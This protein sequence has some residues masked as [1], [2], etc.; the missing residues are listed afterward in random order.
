MWKKARP[1]VLGIT[2][3]VVALQARLISAREHDTELRNYL[4]QGNLYLEQGKLDEALKAF[5]AA[6]FISGSMGDLD[7]EASALEGVSRIY[8]KQGR[9]EEA[10]KIKN[11]ALN[12]RKR[13]RER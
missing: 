6:V 11:E 13:K 3:I 9:L 7:A 12:L 4:S 2:I 10:Q 8:E 5:G 1:V